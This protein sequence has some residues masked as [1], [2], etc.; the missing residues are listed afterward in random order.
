MKFRT[1]RRPIADLDLTPLI[2]VVFQLLLFFL[3]TTTFVTSPGI[4]IQRP[5]ARHSGSLT[6]E[7]FTIEI[8]KDATDRVLF[9]GESLSLPELRSKLEAL[10]KKN[11]DTQI[12]IDADESVEHKRVV[13]VMDT[14]SGVGF[15]KIGIVTSPDPKP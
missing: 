1:R 4:S 12:A 5:K 3:V 15:Q 6:P 2:D 10:H 7:R 8:P 9:Q 14:V 11:P 13:A